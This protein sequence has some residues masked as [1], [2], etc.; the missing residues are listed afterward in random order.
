[1]KPMKR[2]WLLHLAALV[3]LSIG[4]LLVA[5][6]NPL[7]ARG[8]PEQFCFAETGY[9]IEGA[10]RAYWERGGGLATFGY[11]ISDMRTE[12]R[13][14]WSGAVQWFER[15]RLEDHSEQGVMASRL[16]ADLLAAQGRPWHLFSPADTKPAGCL[17]FVATGHSLCEPFLSHWRSS[18]ELERSG[19]PITEPFIE[20]IAGWSGTVQYFERRRMELHS[21]LPGSPI[22]FGLLGRELLAMSPTSASTAPASPSAV[23]HAPGESAPPEP[24]P[25]PADE[26]APTSAPGAPPTEAPTP[27]ATPPLPQTTASDIELAVPILMYH[28]IREVDRASD[29]AGYDLSVAPARF[30]VQLDWLAREGYTSLRMSELAAC[31][32]GERLCPER[33]VA[34]TFDDGYA[35][36]YTM[37]LP[38]LQERGFV[39]TFYIVTSFVGQ[40]GYMGWEELRMLRDAGME[41]GSHGTTHTDLTTMTH[42]EAR[43]ELAVSR[44]EIGAGLQVVVESFCYPY[45]Q[46]STDIRWLVM[47]AGYG[48]AVATVPQQQTVDRYALARLRISN[49]TT[50]TRFRQMVREASQP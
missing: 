13:E 44:E 15:D 19:Y 42:D 37:A 14:G 20:T 38:M 45:G 26:P 40:P 31:L 10:I 6:A 4:L 49:H 2:R 12:T 50:H 25:L 39:A 35:D 28:Y 34:L 8:E 18:G 48:N 43:K 1:M 27:T 47:Q 17:Y 21:E 24:P 9:C 7:P 22:L 46:F 23:H 32:R 33:A 30:A 16:G 11:P 41:I 29:P 36:A 3:I 5:G